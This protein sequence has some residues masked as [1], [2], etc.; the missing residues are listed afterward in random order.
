MLLENY[1]HFPFP[2]IIINDIEKYTAIIFYRFDFS[3]CRFREKFNFL[4]ISMLFLRKRWGFLWDAFLKYYGK[5]GFWGSILEESRSLEKNQVKETRENLNI[6]KIL[7][8]HP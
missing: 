4:D 1:R 3:F 6:M 5:G 8:I 2:S 7:T